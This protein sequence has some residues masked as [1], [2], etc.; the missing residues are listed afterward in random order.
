MMPQNYD[1]FLPNNYSPKMPETLEQHTFLLVKVKTTPDTISVP[2]EVQR[3]AVN[4]T[5]KVV[6]S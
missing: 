2:C 4:A 6:L 3:D 5:V 1:C